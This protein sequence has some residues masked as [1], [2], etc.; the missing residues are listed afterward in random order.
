MTSS[1]NHRYLLKLT[2]S[3]RNHRAWLACA[4]KLS[5]AWAYPDG[6][7]TKSE[8]GVGERKWDARAKGREK[9]EQYLGTSGV[10]CS[11]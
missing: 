10:E 4:P 5:R 3:V 8:E 6:P 1:Q 2:N 9:R 11:V 7:L